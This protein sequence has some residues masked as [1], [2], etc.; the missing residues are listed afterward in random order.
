MPDA[1]GEGEPERAA[2]DDPQDGAADVAAAD[3]GAHG[4]GQAESDENGDERDRDPQRCR[5]QQDGQQRQCRPRGERQRRRARGLEG[6]SE[7]VGADVQLGVEMGGPGIP[8]G[9]LLGE[10][11]GLPEAGQ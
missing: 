1:V 4:T 10:G 2:D 3:A 8:G 11:P 7:V 6:T 5:G 9:E